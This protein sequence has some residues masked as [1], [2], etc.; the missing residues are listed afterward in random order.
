MM[1]RRPRLPPL[2]TLIVAIATL[3]T[4]VAAPPRPLAPD[5]PLLGTWTYALPGNGCVET[6]TIRPDGSA[7]VVGGDEVIETQMD[8]SD[9]PDA[10]G[11]YRWVDKI[12]Q[13]NGKGDCRG[14]VTPA[15]LVWT[16]YIR[17]DPTGRKMALCQDEAL[18]ECI[19]PYLR[20]KPQ[21]SERT[22]L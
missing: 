10:R 4:A 9:K 2:A 14:E 3:G 21:D 8:V 16:S 1:T 19:G 11:A 15:G 12:V 7:R 20:A 13:S 17:F 18:R 6:W 5:H 22:K